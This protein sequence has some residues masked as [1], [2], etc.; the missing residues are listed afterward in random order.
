MIRV[1]SLFCGGGMAEE[2]LR[3]ASERTGIATEVVMAVDNW[4]PA[5][6][7]RDANLP[8]VRTTVRSVKDM[9]R[10]D[11]P[12]HDLVIGGPPC[13][14]FSIAGKK[15]GASDP[16][17]CIPD[18]VRLRGET[19]LMENVTSRL[20]ERMGGGW[21]EKFCASDFG[22]VTSRKRWFYSSHILHVIP[23]PGPKR[24]RDIRDYDEDARVIA[25]RSGC[26]VGHHGHYDD[27]LDTLDTLQGHS[28]HGHDVR[29]SGKLIGIPDDVLR[30]GLRGNSAS[31]SAFNDDDVLGS[32]LAN[33]FHANEASKLVGCRNPSILEMARAHSIP[34]T[35]EWAG[36][37]KTQRGQIIANSWPIG[38]GTAVLAATLHAL[39]THASAAA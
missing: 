8:G 19:W 3:R 10:D 35:W 12:P 37:T 22:D 14:P 23:T 4:E 28:W 5:A 21:S 39:T 1:V 13:Q 7:V 6:R 38:M 34:D 20:L 29:G 24:I 36:T 15:R 18:F 33:A 9:T 25:K 2:A 11:L 27:T 32:L 17:D 30:I 16:R 26:K 31:A